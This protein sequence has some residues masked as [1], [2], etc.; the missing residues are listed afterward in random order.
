[1]TIYRIVQESLNNI[2]KHARPKTV[3]ISL[4]LRDDTVHLT[5]EDNGAGF[6]R[7]EIASLSDLPGRSIGLA[8][9]KER[10]IQ[11]GGDF[12]IESEKGKGSTVF[13]EI[14][15]TNPIT[16]EKELIERELATSL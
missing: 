11:A 16:S 9:M 5:V 15:L 7:R 14:P 13:A 3:F 2:V 4:L 6:D 8:I 10:A 12:W 1:M